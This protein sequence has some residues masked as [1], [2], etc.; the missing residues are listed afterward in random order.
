MLKKNTINDID[1]YYGESLK[2]L[3]EQYL[4]FVNFGIVLSGIT[5]GIIIKEIVFT[6]KDN[7]S[8]IIVENFLLIKISLFIAALAGLFFI[9]C[10]WS[11]QI[12]MERQIYGD[13]KKAKQYF[14][15][16]DT[17]L[18]S[19]LELKIVLN[20][21]V[22]MKRFFN[23]ISIANEIFLYSATILMLI[24]WSILIYIVIFV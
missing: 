2:F 1:K 18:P 22:N 5:I 11:S 8:Q 16:T 20:F 6:K 4:K 10:R 17:I 13:I 21:N 19:A 23:L 9:L 24:S 7:L 15:K 14:E 12:I 3:W